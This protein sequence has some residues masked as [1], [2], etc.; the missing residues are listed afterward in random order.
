MFV[1]ASWVNKN[2]STTT[3]CR[4]RRCRDNKTQV[5]DSTLLHLLCWRSMIIKQCLNL[6]RKLIPS[7]M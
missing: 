1:I 6:R 7:G 2:R 5:I 4:D 3:I